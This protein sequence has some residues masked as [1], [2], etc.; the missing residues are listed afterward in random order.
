MEVRANSVHESQRSA[1][2]VQEQSTE[3]LLLS[4]GLHN[5]EAAPLLLWLCLL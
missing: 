5:H 4:T 3:S 2:G 1:E